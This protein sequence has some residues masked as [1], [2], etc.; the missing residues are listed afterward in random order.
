M[1]KPLPIY[2]RTYRKKHGLTQRE[3]AFLLGLETGQII[4]RYEGMV[5]VPSLQTAIAYQLI[6][7]RPLKDLFPD[8]Y[9]EVEYLTLKRAL[10]LREEFHK[11]PETRK[12][13]YKKKCLEG[14]IVRT[15]A[16]TSI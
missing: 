8:I 9:Q 15:D 13:E 10:A 11:N 12:N 4:S 3:T 14:T 16:R 7:G 2:L 5:R 1:R 6:F